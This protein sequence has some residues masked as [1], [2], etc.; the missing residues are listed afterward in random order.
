MKSCAQTV[1]DIL[2]ERMAPQR[3][4]QVGKALSTGDVEGALSRVLP[5]ETF[6]L[7]GGI[8]QKFPGQR[9][10]WGK[11]GEELGGTFHPLSHGGQL[12]AAV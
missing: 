2:A 7:T 9:G 12:E 11:A 5:G 8:R 4:E 6:Y 1:L 3:S 10:H